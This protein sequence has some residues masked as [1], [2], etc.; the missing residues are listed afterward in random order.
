M[1]LIA[2]SVLLLLPFIWA[3]FR[4]LNSSSRHRRS[5]KLPP[6]PYPIPIIGNI[7][8]LG[9]NPHQTLAK[10]SKT[11]GPIM[12][13]KLGSRDTIVVSSP[14]IAKEILQKH[15]QAFPLRMT[16]AATRALDRHMT[17]VAFLP[18]G[19]QWGNLRKICK[20]QM[21]STPR[22][23]A[24]QGLRQEQLQRLLQYIQEC[25]VKGRAV[26]IGQAAM[27]T[28]INLM[29]K[30][31][32]SVDF[33][34][35]DAGSCEE[36]EEIIRR[37]MRAWGAPNLGD[38]FGLLGVATRNSQGRKTD[39][40]EVLL[41][42]SDANQAELTREEMKHLLLV[43]ADT[44][45]G[46]VEWVMTELMRN[47]Q[48]MLKLKTEVRTIVGA[49]NQVEESDISK[50]PYLQAV[51]KEAF[52]YHPPGPFLMRRK[53]GDDLEIKNYFIPK[54][55]VILINIW[56]IGRDPS[57][58]P[59]PHSFEPERFL[60]SEVDTKGHD[61]ELIPF[62]GGRRICPG[63]PLAQRMLH[64]TVASLVHNF[65]WE[66][67]PGNAP[68]DVDLNEKFGLSLQKAVP[69]KAV[70]TKP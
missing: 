67:E 41:E 45:A 32:F 50:L 13:V 18:V 58:W 22:L 36:L 55:A 53:D 47:P 63:V 48:V 10:L 7:L 21:F 20:E 42:I 49:N 14:E 5:A 40:L 34:G 17:S 25:C 38:Y 19:R 30:T 68:E 29:S 2:C 16:T 15:D 60:N 1:D 8:Q 12:H 4:L 35:Y 46:A 62:G 51:I 39:L 69:L 11:Y 65:D 70:P 64:V 3:C 9:Q 66:L 23:Y 54:Y 61:F 37:L 44:T 24:N 59:N 56:A 26:D 57:I 27:V 33:A 31:L 43:R 28:A 6:G 52:R